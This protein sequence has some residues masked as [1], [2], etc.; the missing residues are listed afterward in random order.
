MNVA[1]VSSSPFPAVVGGTDR[2]LEGLCSALGARHPTDLITIP[3][4]EST[5]EGIVRGY[6]DF[7]HLDLARYDLVIRCRAPAYMAR[8]CVEDAAQAFGCRRAGDG[9]ESPNLHVRV[10]KPARGAP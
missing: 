1:V 6:Y 8:R 4:D 2:F 5:H 10:A 3:C 9:Y 7:F